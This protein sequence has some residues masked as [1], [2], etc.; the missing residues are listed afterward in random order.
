M[1]DGSGNAT[2]STQWSQVCT[3]SSPNGT[4]G[5]FYDWIEQP[6]QTINVR[7]DGTFRV[8]VTEP[9]GTGTKHFTWSFSPLREPVGP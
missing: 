3:M 1:L 8:D 4:D 9:Y 5:Y 2:L 6:M 7:D